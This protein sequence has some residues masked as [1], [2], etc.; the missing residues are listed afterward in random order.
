MDITDASADRTKLAME[1]FLEGHSIAFDRVVFFHGADGSLHVS[2]ASQWLPD[3]VTEQ[4]ARN[5]LNH[6]KQVMM[7]LSEISAEFRQQVASLPHRYS[8]VND[9]GTGAVELCHLE[10]DS[11]V[12]ARGFPT[13]T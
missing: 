4:T 1:R 7:H 13:P 3:N 10:G 9:Y 6:A 12:W 8:V 5:D 11:L 2:V